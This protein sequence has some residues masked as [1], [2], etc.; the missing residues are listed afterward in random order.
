M[1]TMNPVTKGP[2]RCVDRFERKVGGAELNFAIGVARLGLNC[3]WI[4]RLGKDEV[5]K[6]V[7]N[8]GRGEG[9][10]VSEVDLKN[11]YAMPLNSKEIREDGSGKTF[12][13][14]SNSPILTL[15]PDDIKDDI[16]NDVNLLHLSGVYLS[17]CKENIEIIKK[18][19]VLAEE[20]GVL[21]S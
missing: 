21:I 18:L 3:R 13:Y 17:V 11:D 19:I 8:Y 20:K 10:D 16:F 4:S 12:Y 14:R 6:H 15:T 2:L 5:G 7:Y 1:I 9:I